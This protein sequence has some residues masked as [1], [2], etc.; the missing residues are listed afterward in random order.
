MKRLRYEDGPLDAVDARI[1]KTLAEDARTSV[2][3]IARLVGLSGPSVSERIRRLEENG[4]IDGY[5]VRL[6]ASGI[7]LPIAAWLRV[8]PLPGELSRVTEILR[9]LP[10]V[11]EC[12]RITG[13]DCFIAKAHVRSMEHLE[14]VID[15]II[16]FAMTNTSII[17]SSPVRRR[18]PAFGE[19][20][21]PG[22]TG[23]KKPRR[24]GAF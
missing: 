1:I 16:P 12:D 3:D 9:G 17:Q 20:E 19:P 8:R 21:E 18:L 2:A 6:N 10:E 7:G 5:T 11:V 23:T 15:R 14:K 13:D 22:D 24:T 4:V